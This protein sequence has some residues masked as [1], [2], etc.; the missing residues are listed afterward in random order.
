MCSF[1]YLTRINVT[2]YILCVTLLLVHYFELFFLSQFSEFD[3]LK[4]TKQ[5]SLRYDY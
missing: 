3:L 4:H 2:D 1:R 5:S